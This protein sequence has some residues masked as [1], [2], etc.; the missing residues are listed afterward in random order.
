MKFKKLTK[1]SEQEF[2]HNTK[3]PNVPFGIVNPENE[4]EYFFILN[5]KVYMYLKSNPVEIFH[6]SYVSHPFFT[7]LYG[8]ANATQ[9]L[10]PK[11][12]KFQLNEGHV[13]K[14]MYRSGVPHIKITGEN[15]PGLCK[16]LKNEYSKEVMYTRLENDYLMVLGTLNFV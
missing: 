1:Y 2:I 12:I 4:D 11:N 10:Y 3:L 8:K 15:L 7:S 5:G 9:M 14:T 13:M 6:I 16:K